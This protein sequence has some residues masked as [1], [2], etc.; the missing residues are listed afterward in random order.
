MSDIDERIQRSIR[1]VGD[2]FSGRLVPEF[3]GGRNRRAAV[4]AVTVAVVV[5]VPALL[6]TVGTR[7]PQTALEEPGV[8]TGPDRL[9]PPSGDT[10]PEGTGGVEVSPL[11]TPVS[12]PLRLLT[13]SHGPDRFVLT[14]LATGAATTYPRGL[15][16][17]PHETLSGAVFT[18]DG[19]LIVWA[20][21]AHLLPDA[22][23]DRALALTPRSELV[24]A[25]IAPSF[26]VIPTPA[27]D[28][29]WLLQ[30]GTGH[31]QNPIVDLISLH[32][33]ATILS[34]PIPGEIQPVGATQEGDLI[35]NVYRPDTVEPADQISILRLSTDGT[36]H[37]IVDGG[38]AVATGATRILWLACPLDGQ[39]LAERPPTGPDCELWT[40]NTDGTDEVPVNK[41][42]DAEWVQVG[43]PDSPV[44]SGPLPVVSPDGRW[45]LAALGHDLDE[46][47]QPA[48]RSLVRVDL[49]SGEV[50]PII[51]PTAPGP[52]VA[53]WS[54]DGRWI[55]TIRSRDL[56][57][58]DTRDTTVTVPIPD[59]LPADSTLLAAG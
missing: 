16:N 10:G 9:V 6:A 27:G 22:R 2:L 3:S 48:S 40:S 33:G 24:A 17:L 51:E 21:T 23:P 5:A 45:A 47:R 7:P 52:L 19:D 31:D 34:V 42:P 53:T 46:N 41:N 58:I 57:V 28:H 18:P 54:R 12:L 29:A 30:L 59:V 37:S 55:V 32:D 20:D 36:Y 44:D 49:L 35:L 14:D 15:G 1:E 11:A 38:Y 26:R 50:E 43:G 25:G 56:L 13:V 39:T 4:V 8:G